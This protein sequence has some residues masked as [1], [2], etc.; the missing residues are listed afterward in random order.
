M[1]VMVTTNKKYKFQALMDKV[2]SEGIL[3]EII[4]DRLTE[5]SIRTKTKN[6][7]DRRNTDYAFVDLYRKLMGHSKD[8]LPCIECS[9]FTI[10]ECSRTSRE[11]MKFKKYVSVSKTII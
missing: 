8:K 5:I 6:K 10:D 9:D 7:Y 2:I 1:R 3:S 11:C 4:C